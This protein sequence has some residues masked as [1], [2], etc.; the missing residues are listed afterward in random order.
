M[1]DHRVAGLK[2]LGA[3]FV[4][5]ASDPQTTGYLAGLY[6]SATKAATTLRFLVPGN[7]DANVHLTMY[8]GGGTFTPL[9]F[10][11]YKLVHQRVI[12][13][14]LPHLSLSTPYGMQVTS[15][16]PIFVSALTRQSGENGGDFAWANQLTPL[17]NFTLNMAGAS[18]QFFFVGSAPAVRARWI[19]VHGKS[20]SIVI[21]GDTSALW[22]PIGALN[23]VTFTILTKSPIYGGVLVSNLD[24]GLNYLP[25]HPNQ[26]VSRA[27]TPQQDVRALTRHQ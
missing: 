13:V 20:Q 4:T 12:D 5:A 2:D 23:G 26:L 7:I 14:Q 18:G 17:S 3:S 16:Q 9:G 15:D 11:S 19:D 22:H 6:G 25:L 1:L 27:R 24:G 21:S 10:D 8:S